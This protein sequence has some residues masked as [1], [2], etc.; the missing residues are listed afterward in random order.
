MNGHFLCYP[1]GTLYYSITK[2]LDDIIKTERT[3][4]E[5]FST[6]HNGTQSARGYKF[7]SVDRNEIPKYT[8][9]HNNIFYRYICMAYKTFLER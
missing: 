5:E 1:S 6:N 9:H 7:F 3:E 2:Y 4:R 8:Y